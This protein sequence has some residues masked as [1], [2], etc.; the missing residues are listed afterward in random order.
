MVH[1][2]E[3]TSQQAWR[4]RLLTQALSLSCQEAHQMLSMSI[5]LGQDCQDR[6]PSLL[7]ILWRALQAP[8]SQL[9]LTPTLLPVSMAAPD[10]LHSLPWNV[11][12]PLQV[13]SSTFMML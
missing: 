6:A 10:P 7:P 11:R 4:R 3:A 8:A 13:H 9:C 1:K 5:P 12:Q 2:W